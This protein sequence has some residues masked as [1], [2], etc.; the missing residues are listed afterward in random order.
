MQ[1]SGTSLQIKEI[2][3]KCKNNKKHVLALF[4]Y[5]FFFESR[6]SGRYPAY[7]SIKTLVSI[8]VAGYETTN[9]IMLE[10]F[11]IEK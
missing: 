9:K 10:W 2:Q 4:S 6:T 11:K 7:I 3:Q 5:L 1:F 8:K